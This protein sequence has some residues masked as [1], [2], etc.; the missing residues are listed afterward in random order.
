MSMDTHRHLRLVGGQH[1]FR[2]EDEVAQQ[3]HIIQSGDIKLYQNGRDGSQHI[4]DFL[5]P[6]AW[7]GLEALHQQRRQVGAVALNTCQVAAIPYPPPDGADAFNQRLSHAIARH[8]QHAVM[9]RSTSAIQRV[10]QFLLQREASA[11]LPMS[12]QDMADY[13]GLT[14]STVSRCL[15]ALRRRGWLEIVQRRYALPGRA[16]VGQMAQGRPL[17]LDD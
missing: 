12:R 6:G 10:A 14:P 13:L 11:T 9:L 16:E 17:P 5:G 8:Q 15:G 7:V 3:L 1:L 4:V 2:V